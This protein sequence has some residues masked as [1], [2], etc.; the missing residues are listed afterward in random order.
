MKGPRHCSVGFPLRAC[1]PPRLPPTLTRAPGAPAASPG[2]WALGR[3]SPCSSGAHGGPVTPTL[4]P[5]NEMRARCNRN[6][7]LPT[8]T[9][10]LNP[11]FKVEIQWD[12]AITKD[13]QTSLQQTPCVTGNALLD[14]STNP[15]CLLQPPFT[16]P[17]NPAIRHQRE[18]VQEVQRPRVNPHTKQ[19]P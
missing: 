13:P 2:A 14:S 17:D 11:S 8:T 15:D 5:T 4:K 12:G 6:W 1:N 7:N 9:F 16:P 18:R 3:T 10:T 19:D